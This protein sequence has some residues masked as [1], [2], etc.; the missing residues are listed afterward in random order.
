MLEGNIYWT[1]HPLF[2]HL[3]AK[4]IICVLATRGLH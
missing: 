4:I 2:P 3:K 1:Y